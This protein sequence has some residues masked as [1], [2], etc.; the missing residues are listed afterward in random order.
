MLLGWLMCSSAS[1]N[2]HIA[3]SSFPDAIHSFACCNFSCNKASSWSWHPAMQS[4]RRK[5]RYRTIVFM[6][7]NVLFFCL[8]NKEVALFSPM[9]AEAYCYVEVQ[10]LV[11][12]VCFQSVTILEIVMDAWFSIDAEARGEYIFGTDGG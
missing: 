4:I 2:I 3:F 12:V 9:K 8:N 5:K 11:V 10:R 1:F 6:V 7:T